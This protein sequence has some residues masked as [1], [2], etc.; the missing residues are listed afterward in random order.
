MSVDT[1]ITKAHEAFLVMQNHSLDERAGWLEAAAN[2]L[3]VNRERLVEVGQ[4]DTNLPEARLNG[5]LTRTVFQLQLL[6]QE[7]RQ[8]EF[9]DATIDHHDPDWG[10]GPRP[11]IRRLNVPLG[12]VGVFG[13]SN[14]PFAFSVAG[15]DTASA[16]AAGCPVVHKIHGG[17][18]ELGEL[19]AQI[20]IDALQEAG[21]PHGMF[22]AITGREAGIE[23]VEHPKVK[24]IGFTGS[25]PGGRAL[26]D[27]ATSRPEP[28]PF[29]GE[30][31]SINPVVVTEQAWD[32]RGDEIAEGF[33]SSMT[34]GIGQ[35]CTKP[36][37][38]FVPSAI[39]D[40]ARNA[41]THALQGVE[42]PG[43]MLN[44]RIAEGF[45]E[46]RHHIDH[47][48]GV[49][50]ITEMDS[51]SSDPPAPSVFYAQAGELGPDAEVLHTE[52][53][54]PAA[55]VISYENSEE[56]LRVLG[57][58]PGQLTGTVHAEH[59]ENIEHLMTSLAQRCGR[60]LKNGWPTGVTVTYAQHH[61]GP[62]PATTALGTSVGTAA[63]SRFLRAVAYQDF[64]DADLPAPLQDDNPLGL[65]RRVDGD[66]KR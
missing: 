50:R 24:A 35:F 19:T 63:V 23:M 53:F 59:E 9:L 40:Q 12:V 5:E 64:T 26:F 2:A 20:V 27:R 56:L 37:L 42:L 38:V 47:L 45:A 33:V 43:K 15:G 62:Y 30:L 55:V 57:H 21:A 36:G 32:S 1:K 28:I 49:T 65:R 13:A 22:S 60:L 25:V 54:G 41:I 7:V 52:M 51:E 39:A 48:D 6:A 3:E 10:M 31:G 8:G 46:A 18:V 58:L 4:K 61:G 34:M 17:H 29:Y 66:W 14:F 11:D 16:W 44:D